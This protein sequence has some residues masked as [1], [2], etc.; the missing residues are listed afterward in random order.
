[1]RPAGLKSITTSRMIPKIPNSYFGTSIGVLQIPTVEPPGP[2]WVF[3]Q[4]PMLARPSR[5]R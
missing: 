3:S 1:M 2:K 4:P 5:S